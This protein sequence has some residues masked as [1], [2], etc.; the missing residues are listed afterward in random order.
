MI[1]NEQLRNESTPKRVCGACEV[2]RAEKGIL[3]KRNGN[4]KKKNRTKTKQKSLNYGKCIEQNES[5]NKN[6]AF[7][8]CLND[9]CRCWCEFS[10][11]MLAVDSLNLMFQIKSLETNK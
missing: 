6:V 7:I 9:Y 8:K 1:G 5:S 4:K 10:P 3:R 2:D 11:K